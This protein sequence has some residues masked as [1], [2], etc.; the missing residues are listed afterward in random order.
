MTYNISSLYTSQKKYKQAKFA[1]RKAIE[2]NE[3]LKDN[4]RSAI[5]TAYIKFLESFSIYDTGIKSLELANQN[6]E[7]IN[8]RYLND[9]AL[10]TDMI[11]A[12]NS[13]HNEE[14]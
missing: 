13:N 14:V 9:L 11:D 4:L 3:Y 5:K 10:I 2:A 12:S 6:Y 8:N 7:V 1:T